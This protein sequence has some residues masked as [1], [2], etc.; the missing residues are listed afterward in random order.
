[1]EN[2]NSKVKDIDLSSPIPKVGGSSESFS[3]KVFTNA[4]F[5][6]D[7]EGR[8]F[9]LCIK[10]GDV[11]S[12]ILSVGDAGRAER[13]ALSHLENREEPIKSSRG[14]VT[15]TGT[16]KGIRI[17]SI[18]TG[19][20]T[21]MMDFVV[22][23][24][25]AVIDSSEE[26]KIIRFGTCGGLQEEDYATTIVVATEGSVLIRRE[27]D[28]IGNDDSFPYSISRIVP[29]C[30]ILS[31]KLLEHMQER[32]RGLLFTSNMSNGEK[33]GKVKCGL[34]ITADSFYS[35]QGRIGDAFDDRNDKLLEKVHELY[36]SARSCQ[37]ETF[38]LFDLARSS[39][40]RIK[41]AAACIILASRTT[42]GGA[43]DS[44]ASK[45]DVTLLE[46]CGGLACL[47]ALVKDT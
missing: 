18:A 44:I 42:K 41:A 36:P 37:M 28:L 4:N 15:H 22:R 39:L 29:P 26:M 45:E 34:D 33:N 24:T 10:R 14:F 27:P 32:T 3:G 16:F 11:A 19:M 30:S 6:T 23:E 7:V 17:S 47:E 21:S 46:L 43:S 12:R 1:M 13:I 25:R 20:G 2:I 38:H 40:H 5:P 31:N 35:S 8:T 9:H